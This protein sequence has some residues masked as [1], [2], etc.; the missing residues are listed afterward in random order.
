MLI[1]LSKYIFWIILKSEKVK[2]LII[3]FIKICCF[4]IFVW[5]RRNTIY[6]SVFWI[7][8]FIN[9]GT[10]EV[11]ITIYYNTHKLKNYRTAMLWHVTVRSFR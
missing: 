8:E 2:A 6:E 5:D 4:D 7:Y 3:I 11:A 10:K 1:D 9:T